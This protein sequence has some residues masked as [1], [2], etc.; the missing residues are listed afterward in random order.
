MNDIIIYNSPFRALLDK[1][2]YDH[3]SPANDDVLTMDRLP[4]Q[5]QSFVESPLAGLTVIPIP[6]GANE[7]KSGQYLLV[8]RCLIGY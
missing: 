1:P 4:K 2:D 3:C 5:C 6:E 8:H 7:R